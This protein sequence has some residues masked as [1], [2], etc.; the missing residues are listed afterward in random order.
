MAKMINLTTDVL[1]NHQARI[2]LP[3]DAPL[4]PAEMERLQ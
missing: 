2:A 1:P 3:D 4:G